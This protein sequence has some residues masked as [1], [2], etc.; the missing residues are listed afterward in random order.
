MLP[1]QL[2]R[3][4][5]E[6]PEKARALDVGGWS[7]P[8]NRA[9]YVID[10]MPYQTRGGLLRELQPEAPGPGEQV[11]PPGM[12]AR[13]G[14]G[15]GPERFGPDTWVQRDICDHEPWPFEDDFFDF[16][17]CSQTLEDLRDP[18]WVCKEIS[19]VGKRGYV[20]VPSLVDE[21]S[22]WVPEPSGGPWLG[23]AHHRWI[24]WEEDGELVFLMKWHN[25]HFESH[26]EV[27]ARWGA[28]LDID[29]RG[30]AIHWRGELRAREYPAISSYPHEELESRIAR[31][32]GR[33]AEELHDELESERARGGGRRSVVR[34]LP[35]AV[36]RRVRGRVRKDAA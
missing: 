30:L 1:D 12:S 28:T 8:V 13:G 15:P 5:G 27:P 16:V 33:S 36:V 19:R 4:L 9:D 31:Y 17:F 34:R 22:R 23:H 10:L 21:L 3:I 7:A 25:L 18:V 11:R 20:E 35:G 6:L 24:C 29:D 2:E 26:V 14:L 32:F